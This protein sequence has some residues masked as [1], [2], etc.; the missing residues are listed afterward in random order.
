M[1]PCLHRR[2]VLRFGAASALLMAGCATPPAPQMKLAAGEVIVKQR[3]AVTADKPWNHF[4][5][6]T[7]DEV[8][9]WTQEGLVIDQLR[10][11][12]GLKDGAL[13][14]P[15]P[16]EPKGMKPLAFAAAM[17]ARDV[18]ALFEGYYSRFGST[19]TLN[20]VAPLPF[21]GGDGF[22]FEFG[23][24]RKGDDVRLSG[25]GWGAIR[26]GELT[27]ITYTAPRLGFFERH[28]GSAEAIAKS[29]RWV[30]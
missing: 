17:Q 8:P 9:V 15:T 22:R 13:I 19:F 4:D 30:N 3:L 12:V 5:R 1:S 26:Q 10:Y 27:V 6:G 24:I 14:A 2:A 20:R 18:V 23:V 28:A 11:Y 21:L 16:S 25:V 29:A 7:D